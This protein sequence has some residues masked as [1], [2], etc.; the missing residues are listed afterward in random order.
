MATYEELD[1]QL[2][3]RNFNSR[4]VGN[5]TYLIRHE[6][7][8]ALRLHNTDVVTAYPD[9]RMMLNSGGWM[10]PTTKNRMNSII[11][12]YYIYQQDYS[13]YIRDNSG[14][15]FPYFDGMTLP[16]YEEVQDG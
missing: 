6:N 13:W 16:V 5:N 2:Q 15:V 7:I 11:Y 14:E 12:P 9:G 1:N 8:I 3:G 10:T 4:K